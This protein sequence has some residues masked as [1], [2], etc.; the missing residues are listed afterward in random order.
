MIHR[1]LNVRKYIMCSPNITIGDLT[2]GLIVVDTDP[3][4]LQVTVSVV[5]PCGIDAMLIADDF[6]KLRTQ[7]CT[8]SLDN[9]VPNRVH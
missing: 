4:Q 2:S 1:I 5:S 9:C 7:K 6:P 3:V 8:V